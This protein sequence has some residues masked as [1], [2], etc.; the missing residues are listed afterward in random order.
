MREEQVKMKSRLGLKLLGLCA[1][2]VGL[3]AFGASAAQA[4]ESGGKWLYTDGTNVVGVPE[5]EAFG[6]EFE[7][8]T[9]GTLLTEILKK[10]LKSY[11]NL[12]KSLKV[13]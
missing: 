3:T 2:V 12:L 8:S 7:A 11:V 9:D 1:L 10:K 6:G 5:G 4:E 13:N